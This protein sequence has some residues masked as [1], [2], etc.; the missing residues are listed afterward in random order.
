M[1]VER[2]TG[3][4]KGEFLPKKLLFKKY[5]G[6]I[7]DELTKDKISFNSPFIQSLIFYEQ[8]CRG[9]GPKLYGITE[10]GRVEEFVDCHTL[11]PVEAF[12][13]E[14][15]KDVAKAYARFHSY[16][17]PLKKKPY[18]LIDSLLE[19]VEPNKKALEESVKSK[20]ECDPC[21]N[22]LLQYPFESE[23]KW[24]KSIVSKM[25]QRDV[26]CT[27]DPNYLNRLVKNEKPKNENSIRTQ[28]IDFDLT[29]Y[30]PRGYD[31]AG[32]FISRLLDPTQ[33]DN[34][35]SGHPYPSESE[36]LSFLRF[37]LDECKGFFDDFDPSSLDSLENL[38]IEVDINLIIFTIIN[39]M[40]CLPLVSADTKIMNVVPVMDLLL[41]LNHKFKEEF[42]H[43]YPSLI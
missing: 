11:K 4:E 29:S 27:M 3:E 42:I 38:L 8:S 31:L 18:E 20:K 35:I 1:K 7:F 34:L 39:L 30:S 40:L 24:F 22:E 13:S 25:S 5:G 10:T 32:H 23:V 21:L 2:L 17:L 26:L 37:Y 36:R 16:K 41:K 15:M 9:W 14:M 28:I 43:K 33:K 6:A 19:T 12:T